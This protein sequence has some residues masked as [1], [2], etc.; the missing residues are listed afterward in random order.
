MLQ[1]I[2]TALLAITLITGIVIDTSDSNQL[3]HETYK[4]IN[5]D[6]NEDY[7]CVH[8]DHSQ[9]DDGDSLNLE[10]ANQSLLN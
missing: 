8:D 6:S 2:L 10:A 9:Y 5:E 4:T 3:K 1:F 7:G